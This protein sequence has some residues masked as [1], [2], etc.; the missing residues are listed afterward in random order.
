EHTGHGHGRTP[1]N[2]PGQ[3]ATRLR[4]ANG[5]SPSVDRPGHGEDAHGVGVVDLVHH[6]AR[7]RET[8]HFGVDHVHP[9][10]F[11]GRQVA[12][13]RT[14]Y[15][16]R[17]ALEFRGVGIGAVGQVGAVHHPILVADEEVPHLLA[18]AYRLVLHLAHA[19]SHV[20][21]GV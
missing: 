7:Q 19:R 9:L 12:P 18:V 11:A 6:C 13:V 17:F 14:P 16:V 8:R 2:H 10:G 15:G 20:H 21:G 4:V 3:P 5:V 1:G